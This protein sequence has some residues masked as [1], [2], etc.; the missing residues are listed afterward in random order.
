[1]RL[2]HNPILALLVLFSVAVIPVAQAASNA[3]SNYTDQLDPVSAAC[4]SCH[5]GS[6]GPHVRFCLLSQKDKGCGG[7]IISA[8]YSDLAS[9]NQDLQPPSSLPSELVLYQGKI[10]CVTCHGNEPHAG[11]ALV[12]RNIGSALCRACHRK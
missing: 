12:I 9:R 4:L 11:R 2:L 1:M 5:D 6:A 7:H 10:T 8:S 3:P